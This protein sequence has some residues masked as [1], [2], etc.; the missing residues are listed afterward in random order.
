MPSREDH[1]CRCNASVSKET[2]WTQSRPKTECF[3]RKSRYV[4]RKPSFW[5]EAIGLWEDA[6]IMQHSPRRHQ[7]IRHFMMHQYKDIPHIWY[8]GRTCGDEITIVNVILRN[9]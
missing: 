2:I 1:L 9:P 4:W 7:L 5:I 3:V 8:H 6:R